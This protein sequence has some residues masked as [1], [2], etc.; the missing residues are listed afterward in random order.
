MDEMKSCG[1]CHECCHLPAIRDR[2]T[3]EVF[4]SD[5]A[6]CEYLGEHDGCTI[7]G[8]RPIPCRAFNCLWRTNIVLDWQLRPDRCGVMF[9]V[10]PTEKTVIA[11]TRTDAKWYEGAVKQLIDRMVLDDYCVWVI[12][13]NKDTGNKERNIVL[14][15]GVT[16][17]TAEARA[18]MIGKRIEF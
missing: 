5:F 8:E 6:D 9:E 12:R 7:Y 18:K 4:K 14:P 3:H 16:Q 1:D 2:H 17:Q 13:L 10:F 11:L 15:K